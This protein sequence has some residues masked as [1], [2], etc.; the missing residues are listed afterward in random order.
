MQ[1]KTA[2]KN[3]G[4]AAVWIHGGQHVLRAVPVGQDSLGQAGE[5]V[6]AYDGG[7]PNPDPDA[8]VMVPGTSFTLEQPPGTQ[9]WESSDRCLLSLPY[10]ILTIGATSRGQEPCNMRHCQGPPTTHR[11]RGNRWL[12]S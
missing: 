10:D 4:D 5:V 7:T 6:V 3:D 9:T 11:W 8:A 1:S 12:D 2:Q